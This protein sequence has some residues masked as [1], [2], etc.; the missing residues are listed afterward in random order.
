MTSRYSFEP[1][2]TGLKD[3]SGTRIYVLK[4]DFYTVDDD[5]CRIA[6][7]KDDIILS[8]GFIQGVFSKKEDAEAY[9][10]KDLAEYMGGFRGKKGISDEWIESHT[11]HL[12]FEHYEIQEFIL[13]R[14][15]PDPEDQ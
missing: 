10:E 8:N 13:D 12:R 11:E 14:P 7:T 5:E 9:I 1:Y 2:P 4:Y 3:Q 15:D 6:K